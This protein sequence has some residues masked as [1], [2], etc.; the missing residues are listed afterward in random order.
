MIN[1]ERPKN[2]DVK[3]L[4]CLLTVWEIKFDLMKLAIQRNPFDVN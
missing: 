3:D 1:K 4:A 2:F